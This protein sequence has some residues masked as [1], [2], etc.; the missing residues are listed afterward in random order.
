[1][2]RFGASGK[3]DDV[4]AKFDITVDALVRTAR[5]VIWSAR[6]GKSR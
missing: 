5:E 6:D 1:M 3:I 4:Y 2:H